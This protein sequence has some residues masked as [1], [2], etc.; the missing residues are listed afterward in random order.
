MAPYTRGL[1]N[2]YQYTATQR[3]FKLGFH[4][5]RHVIRVYIEPIHSKLMNEAPNEA[6]HEQFRFIEG[7]LYWLQFIRFFRSPFNVQMLHII[8]ALAELDYN[9]SE[10]FLK[11][12]SNTPPG[13]CT[14]SNEFIY[15]E[16]ER[17]RQYPKYPYCH[18]ISCITLFPQCYPVLWLEFDEK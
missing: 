11:M 1:K 14:T 4:E 7:I 10:T 15:R 3:W 13:L 2:L 5:L 17:S 8:P 16:Q 6:V 9:R 12:K 18:P